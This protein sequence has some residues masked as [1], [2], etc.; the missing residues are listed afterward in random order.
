MTPNKK[1]F[2]AMN[3]EGLNGESCGV[4]NYMN[5]II[6]PENQQHKCLC[7]VPCKVCKCQK[8]RINP[9]AIIAITRYRDELTRMD[10]THELSE[11]VFCCN[12]IL[13][14]QGGRL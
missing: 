7:I 12:V 5:T 1:P 9:L 2:N 14:N 4:K 3:E 10:Y 13:M 11:L 8:P 6:K